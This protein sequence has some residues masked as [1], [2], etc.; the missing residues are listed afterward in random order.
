[1]PGRAY[2]R[3]AFVIVLLVVLYYVFRILEPFLAALAWAAILAT[4][5]HPVYASL[6]R[7]LHRPRL[8]SALACVLITALIILPVILLLVLLAGE[9]IQAYRTLEVRIH[10]QEMSRLEFLRHTASY[11]WL[12]G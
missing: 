5:F 10:S 4:V 12:L 6:L 7:R 9:S 1:M 11:Q 8:A 2:G 3:V